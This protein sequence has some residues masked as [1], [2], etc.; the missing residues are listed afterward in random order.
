M[1]TD[2]PTAGELFAVCRIY[3][4]FLLLLPHRVDVPM[5]PVAGCSPGGYCRLKPEPAKALASR[6]DLQHYLTFPQLCRE[7][8]CFLALFFRTLEN[9]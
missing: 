2:T 8:I 7:S 1:I 5:L 3:R 9:F 6:R 4:H